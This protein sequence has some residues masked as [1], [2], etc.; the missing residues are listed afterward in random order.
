MEDIF[1]SAVKGLYVRFVC[2]FGCTVAL[3][4]SIFPLIHLPPKTFQ[5]RKSI[6]LMKTKENFKEKATQGIGCRL[7]R[8]FDICYGRNNGHSAR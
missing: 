4:I 6:L 7:E 1:S 3:G 5:G 8:K 2:S